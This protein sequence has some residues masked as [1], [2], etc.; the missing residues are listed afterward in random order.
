MKFVD[1]QYLGKQ[2][3]SPQIVIFDNFHT[4][5]ELKLIWREIDFLQNPNKFK[6]VEYI[7]P[8]K[9][10]EGNYMKRA[11]GL[12]FESVYLDRTFSDILTINRKIFT[13]QFTQEL[14]SLNPIFRHVLLCNRDTT[15]LSYYKS[16][17]YYDAH[18][19]MSLITVLNYFNEEP[20][21]F[22]GG[23]LLFNDFNIEIEIKNNRTIL[24]PGCYSHQVL[25]ITNLKEGHKGRY[26]IAQ[27]LNHVIPDDVYV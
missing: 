24:F 16:G 7:K 13:E 22:D 15:L 4:E 27:F 17:G 3:N 19:D 2:E 26:C 11:S 12:F 8:A 23:N 18:Q 1:C 10:T 25:P 20:K 9:D 6:D 5:D 14:I 21:P